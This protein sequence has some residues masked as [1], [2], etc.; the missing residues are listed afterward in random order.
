MAFNQKNQQVSGGQVNI[1]RGARI[2]GGIHLGGG[3]G[4]DAAD[5]AGVLTA[6]LAE[7]QQAQSA[8]HISEEVAE[9]VQHEVRQAARTAQQPTPDAP[10]ITSR[11]S[12]A[13][14]LVSG[15]GTAVSLTT[16]LTNAI[17]TAQSLF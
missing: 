4:G 9:D 5:L 3:P 11:L 1:A 17:H 2:S 8:G 14:D 10:A 13:R 16:A 6:L 12:R 15:I 7:I